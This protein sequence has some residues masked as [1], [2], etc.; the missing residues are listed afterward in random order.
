ML[1]ISGGAP[2]AYSA[3]WTMPER[4]RAIAVVS[5]APP[6]ADVAYVSSGLHDFARS[7]NSGIEVT[8]MAG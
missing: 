3:A 5:G 4:V 2:Y 8:P 7:I 1:A 6:I